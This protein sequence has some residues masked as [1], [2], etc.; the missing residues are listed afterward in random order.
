MTPAAVM[1]ERRWMALLAAG[2]ALM[3]MSLAI[4]TASGAAE[5]AGYKYFN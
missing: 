5:A 4:M 1:R 2:Q 3:G